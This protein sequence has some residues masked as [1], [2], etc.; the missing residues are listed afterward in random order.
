MV[1]QRQ[2]KGTKIIGWHSKAMTTRGP[3]LHTRWLRLVSRNFQR[4]FSL[5]CASKTS[6]SR[7]AAEEGMGNQDDL[8]EYTSGRWMYVQVYYQR[9]LFE[10]AH[11]DLDHADTMNLVALPNAT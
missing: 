5:R 3:L 7:F 11:I 10:I 4:L 6:P 9:L 8:F 2:L 1:L